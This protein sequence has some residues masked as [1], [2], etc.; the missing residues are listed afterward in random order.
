MAYNF[1]IHLGP[2]LLS[3]CWG[4]CVW[5]RAVCRLL[6]LMAAIEPLGCTSHL[7]PFFPCD[8]DLRGLPLLKGS[9]CFL[10]VYHALAQPLLLCVHWKGVWRALSVVFWMHIFF[11]QEKYGFCGLE[12]LVG[13]RMIVRE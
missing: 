10:G 3:P 9:D 11:F 8:C 2:E 7:I 12:V 13:V 1:K 4:S 6:A 5:H